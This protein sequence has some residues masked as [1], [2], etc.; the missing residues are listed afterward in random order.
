MHKSAVAVHHAHLLHSFSATYLT[1]G[2]QQPSIDFF[3]RFCSTSYIRISY[4]GADIWGNGCSHG[5][6]WH[7][8][9][10]QLNWVDWWPLFTLPFRL[11]HVLRRP[12][13]PSDHLIVSHAPSSNFLQSCSWQISC[14]VLQYTCFEFSVLC[15]N[16][17]G[18]VCLQESIKQ[19]SVRHN[20]TRHWQP[21]GCYLGVSDFS[22][23]QFHP[24][25]PHLNAI[26]PIT[27]QYS[28]S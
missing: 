2:S 26:Q 4:L 10:I 6:Y 20:C 27:L 8:K 19:E 15:P 5:N 28:Y 14:R 12:S 21:H 9:S 22:Q 7:Q 1:V 23:T 13:R 17:F 11:G 3:I 25:T 16:A 18:V 24:E